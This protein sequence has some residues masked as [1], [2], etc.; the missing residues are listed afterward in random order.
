M[1][2]GSRTAQFAVGQRVNF[3][4]D[5]VMTAGTIVK[6]HMSGRYGSAEIKPFDGR[7]KLTRMLQH[8][9]AETNK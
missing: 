6:L 7:A 9:S 8:V 5:K 3:S 1:M 2:K 4:T